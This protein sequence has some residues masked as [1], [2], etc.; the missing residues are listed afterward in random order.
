MFRFLPKLSAI[1]LT[2][3]AQN[4]LADETAR[5]L[6]DASP[7]MI[8]SAN[9]ETH[10]GKPVSFAVTTSAI[11]RDKYFRDDPQWK[12]HWKFTPQRLAKFGLSNQKS[13]SASKAAL[14]QTA[15]AIERTIRSFGMQET[16]PDA[17]K[18]LLERK[19]HFPRFIK[20]L[21]EVKT[22][23]ARNRPSNGAIWADEI[24]D[25]YRSD[26][27]SLAA[28]AFSGFIAGLQ[29][30]G[31]EKMLAGG[32]REDL[33][34]LQDEHW[35]MLRKASAELEDKTDEAKFKFEYFAF[36]DEG[37]ATRKFYITSRFKQVLNDAFVILQS[38]SST[39]IH[40]YGMQEWVF[41]DSIFM[42]LPGYQRM[43]EPSKSRANA[44]LKITIIVGDE[45]YVANTLSQ[46]PG[47]QLVSLPLP[48]KGRQDA[49]T[50]LLTPTERM[51][52][53]IS[54]DPVVPAR[55]T[56]QI[57]DQ[58]HRLETEHKKAIGESKRIALKE[59]REVSRVRGLDRSA[60]DTIKQCK[61]D[62][63]D[64]KIPEAVHQLRAKLSG[65]FTPLGIGGFSEVNVE[66]IYPVFRSRRNLE[67]YLR[68]VIVDC[69][70]MSFDDL[71][72]ALVQYSEQVEASDYLANPPELT[73]DEAGTAERQSPQL[74]CGQLA[75]K[76][77]ELIQQRFERIAKQTWER[78][79][80][81]KDQAHKK[82]L[83]EQMGSFRV[84]EAFPEW[85]REKENAYLKDLTEKFD[86][87]LSKIEA[88]DEVTQ[89]AKN[90]AKQ[91]S[92]YVIG[93]L[94]DN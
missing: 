88:Q 10:F 49:L 19:D 40:G 35:R 92:R 41:D 21:D 58:L 85:C 18:Y 6:L 52:G 37:T 27:E 48:R 75:E 65:R 20:A 24:E 93:Q 33:Y 63:A 30:S 79:A 51:R 90:E 36:F 5:E 64:G 39:A 13:Q 80:E 87:A 82:D 53:I 2:L 16:E 56:K 77:V 60:R 8:S 9:L 71:R 25:L 91:L 43:F 44:D 38:E 23:A 34:D 66:A 55:S 89:T 3:L 47:F 68:D 46:R 76:Y 54:F 70:R 28:S 31:Y 15:E 14:F 81:A 59:I 12:S 11:Y 42:R 62:L 86:N 4:T 72:I 94:L 67:L 73:P 29:K 57:V 61:R 84:R 50:K 74:K 45:V 7:F 26:F 17:I 1:V 78:F 83:E 32:I 22:L 69:E